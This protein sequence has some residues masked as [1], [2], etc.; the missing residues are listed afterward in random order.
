MYCN[1]S[2]IKFRYPKTGLQPV[3]VLIRELSESSEFSHYVCR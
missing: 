1:V 3:G 2:L